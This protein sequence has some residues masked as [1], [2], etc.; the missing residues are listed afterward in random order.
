MCRLSHINGPRNSISPVQ[1]KAKDKGSCNIIRKERT[2]C[3]IVK[4]DKVYLQ[5][6]FALELFK[7]QQK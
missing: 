2:S 5:Y 1:P 3:S 6:I 4:C 7:Q